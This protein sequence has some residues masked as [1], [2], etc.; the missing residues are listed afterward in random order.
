MCS[1][2]INKIA[3]HLKTIEISTF[4]KPATHF[5]LD[6]PLVVKQTNLSVHSK[7]D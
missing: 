3:M 4:N 6:E 2:N 7:T 1:H 5:L